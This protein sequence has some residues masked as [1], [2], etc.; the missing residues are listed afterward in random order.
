MKDNYNISKQAQAQAALDAAQEASKIAAKA[1]LVAEDVVAKAASVASK[2]IPASNQDHDTLISFRSETLS[3][4]KNIRT[5]IQNLNDG[6]AIK[7]NDHETRIRSNSDDIISLKTQVKVW[8][9]G[10]LFVMAVIQIL[11]GFIHK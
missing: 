10:I 3:E 4:L 1:V 5:D 2:L 9:T 8:G 6:T 7:I 11:L